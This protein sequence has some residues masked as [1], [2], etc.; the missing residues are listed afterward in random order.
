MWQRSVLL[1][2][3]F[4]T[5]YCNNFK[6]IHFNTN[7]N[8]NY[9]SIL[10]SIKMNEVNPKTTVPFAKNKINKLQHGSRFLKTSLNRDHISLLSK[11]QETYNNLSNVFTRVLILYPIVPLNSPQVSWLDHWIGLQGLDTSICNIVVFLWTHK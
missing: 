3:Y 9:V 10:F 11:S 6:T 4:I 7:T 5:K 1:F 2:S 8:I